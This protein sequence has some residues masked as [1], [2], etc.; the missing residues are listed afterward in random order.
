MRSAAHG[1]KRPL[2]HIAFAFPATPRRKSGRQI[3]RLTIR[4]MDASHTAAYSG[5]HADVRRNG[6]LSGDG[7]AL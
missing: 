6:G 4:P 7:E 3:G 1:S 5:L 2:G